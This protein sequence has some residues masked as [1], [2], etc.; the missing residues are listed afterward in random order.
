MDRGVPS[1]TLFDLDGLLAS[2]RDQISALFS[3]E[4]GAQTY[5]AI[6]VPP[7]ISFE[8]YRQMRIQHTRIDETWASTHEPH[9]KALAR[10]VQDFKAVA[11]RQADEARGPMLEAR[12]AQIRRELRQAAPRATS[13]VLLGEGDGSIPVAH[14]PD[15]GEVAES[16]RPLEKRAVDDICDTTLARFCKSLDGHAAELVRASAAARARTKSEFG[17]KL[18]AVYRARAAEFDRL[19]AA[20]QAEAR[21][22]R[23]RVYGSGLQRQAARAESEL[24]R[25]SMSAVARVALALAD[26]ATYTRARRLVLATTLVL[27]LCAAGLVLWNSETAAALVDP[28]EKT[29]DEGINK[30]YVL[31]VR[32]APVRPS[33][34]SHYRAMLAR[35]EPAPRLDALERGFF[36][37]DGWNVS[38]ARMRTWLDDASESCACAQYLGIDR[39]VAHVRGTMLCDPALLTCSTENARAKTG[40]WLGEGVYTVP[41]TARVEY[42]ASEGAAAGRRVTVQLDRAG[43]ACVLRCADLARTPVGCPPKE[44]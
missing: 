44:V 24:K 34:E 40:D 16:R 22:R 1:I 13:H 4:D 31:N 42:T 21:A 36:E 10:L 19:A 26:P 12:I 35:T 43:V 37:S 3:H 9:P 5:H 18:E 8:D 38:V 29:V 11:K 7:D 30:V 41:T 27:V 33:Y 28:A 6:A 32:V 15:A 39:F 14:E 2:A 20:D 23:F 25:A 17:A